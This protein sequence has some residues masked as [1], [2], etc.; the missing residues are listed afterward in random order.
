MMMPIQEGNS[1]AGLYDTIDFGY[2]PYIRG[3]DAENG[4]VERFEY[5]S[6]GYFDQS[7]VANN[8]EAYFQNDPLV[9]N[10]AIFE[11]F[12]SVEVLSDPSIESGSIVHRL[13]RS[14]PFACQGV[15]GVSDWYAIK[16]VDV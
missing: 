8:Q 14:K 5:T 12:L 9:S 16:L 1:V 10:S 13:T 3:S 7:K 6:S 4:R 2:V 15:C 11:A